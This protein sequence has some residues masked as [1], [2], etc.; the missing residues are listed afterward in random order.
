MLG[1]RRDPAHA[2]LCLFRL[3]S[4]LA[5]LIVVVGL[6]ICIISISSNS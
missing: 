2:V 5:L 4:L 6:F 3:I 1:R